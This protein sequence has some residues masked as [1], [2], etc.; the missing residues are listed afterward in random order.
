MF[1]RLRGDLNDRP[2]D[3]GTE[4][5]PG[6][7]LA[8]LIRDGRDLSLGQ[9][10]DEELVLGELHLEPALGLVALDLDQLALG[11]GIALGQRHLVIEDLLV[12][13]P[14]AA[15]YLVMALGLRQ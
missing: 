12:A 7:P 2:A 13:E 14:L 6:F 5:Q 8:I 3:G 11:E 1:S 9:A 4:R 10:I 15:R